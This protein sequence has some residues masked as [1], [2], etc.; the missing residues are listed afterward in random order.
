MGQGRILRRKA[1]WQEDGRLIAP[2][3]EKSFE[4]E[5]QNSMKAGEVD[6]D[7]FCLKCP[8]ENGKILVSVMEY[9]GKTLS[10]TRCVQEE[11]EVKDGM[12]VL[13]ENE[14]F[15]AVINRHG[16]GTR[17]VALC[18]ISDFARERWHPRF[19]TTPTT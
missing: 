6:L 12:V 15:V 4:I 3:E 19:P 10:I 1:G 13:G 7:D 8:C 16:K 18:A 5:K 11:H 14:A 9:A 17:A 2:V